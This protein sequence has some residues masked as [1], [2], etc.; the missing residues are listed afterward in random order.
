MNLL[1][2][3]FIPQELAHVNDADALMDYKK[4]SSILSLE[5]VLF[6]HIVNDVLFKEFFNDYQNVST[7]S[8]NLTFVAQNHSALKEVS[9]KYSDI[10]ESNTNN[11]G[12]K[13]SVCQGDILTCNILPDGNDPLL[14]LLCEIEKCFGY[15]TAAK[16]KAFKKVFLAKNL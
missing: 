9:D 15:D 8:N 13:V 12:L 16:T 11:F 2:T 7:L 5:E 10:M 1:T 3:V 4:L 14:S 6:Y